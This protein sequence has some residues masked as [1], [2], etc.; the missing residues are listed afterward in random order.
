MFIFLLWPPSISNRVCR[1]IVNEHC[2]GVLEHSLCCWILFQGQFAVLGLTSGHRP[3]SRNTSQSE[4]SPV[5]A[6][7]KPPWVFL[8]DLLLTL[9]TCSCTLAVRQI[10]QCSPFQLNRVKATTQHVISPIAHLWTI[11]SSE[12][13]RLLRIRIESSRVESTLVVNMHV[14]TSCAFSASLPVLANR[15]L[16]GR[17]V[18]FPK[19]N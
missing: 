15:L 7:C 11:P 9:A 3:T 16:L 1:F 8:N 2:S 10:D 14:D 19:T 18:N 12:S 6:C 5:V 17:T 13:D 4:S